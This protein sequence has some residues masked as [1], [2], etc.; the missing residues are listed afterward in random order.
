MNKEFFPNNEILLIK[1]D[2]DNL[3]SI[4]EQYFYKTDCPIARALKRITANQFIVTLNS[5]QDM[6]EQNI[7]QIEGEFKEVE[8]CAYQ[9]L[10]S[11]TTAPIKI[12]KWYE[13]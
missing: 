7:C 10:R 2:F 9:L 5:V 4:F 1:E 13:Q 11:A 8:K 6:Y 12:T 3:S